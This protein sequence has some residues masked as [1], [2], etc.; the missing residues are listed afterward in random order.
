MDY[1]NGAPALLELSVGDNEI[2]LDDFVAALD[3]WLFALHKQRA[4]Q[5]NWRANR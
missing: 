3:D 5:S 1:G 2:P 4:L